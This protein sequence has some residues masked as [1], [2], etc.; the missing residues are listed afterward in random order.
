L[1]CAR[2]LAVSASHAQYFGGF[3]V[4]PIGAS[5]LGKGVVLAWAVLALATA[6]TV[7]ELRAAA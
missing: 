7:R 2:R 6:W 3:G 1:V 5:V 4:E